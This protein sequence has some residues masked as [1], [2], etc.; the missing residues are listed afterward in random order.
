MHHKSKYAL[1]RAELRNPKEEDP[2]FQIAPMIDI[3]LVLLVFFMTINSRVVLANNRNLNL[4]VAKGADLPGKVGAQI[5]LNVK[6][7]PV[8]N[9]G[10]VEI[11]TKSYSKPAQIV[12]LL[13]DTLSRNPDTRV[14]I[15]ADK[16][17]RYLYMREV[18]RAVGNAGAD[19]VTFSVLEKEPVQAQ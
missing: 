3:L 4:A 1:R 5:T 8:A 19:S 10:A 7:L 17:V 6:W 9:L 14:L 18:L 11:N 12:K 2:E 13:Q 16:A 15:R